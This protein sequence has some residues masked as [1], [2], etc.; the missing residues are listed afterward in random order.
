MTRE[1]PEPAATSATGS[2]LSVNVGMPKDVPWQGKTVFTGVFKDPVVGPRRVRRLNVEGDGQ[3]DLA[4][5][6][7]EQRAVFVYQ[8][9]SYRYWER[10]E[11]DRNNFA[12]GQFGENFTVEGLADDEV[13]VGDRY[14]IGGAVFEVTQPRVTCYR[15]GIRMSDPRI[16]AMLVS[17]HRPGFYFRVLKKGTYKRET[18]SSSLP[19]A[20]NRCGSRRSTRCCTCPGTRASSCCARSGSL[21]SAPAGSPRSEPCSRKN[22][23][24]ATPVLR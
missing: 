20:L 22:P 12:Y 6:G 7:G 2:L 1:P 16:P 14:Q 19:L 18:R 21:R 23:A 4:G 8:I 9:D 17:H 10:E 5:H 3:G 24:A 15:V 13:C 11:P